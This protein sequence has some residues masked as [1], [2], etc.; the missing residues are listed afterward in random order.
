[1]NR[2]ILKQIKNL[3]NKTLLNKINYKNFKAINTN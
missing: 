3:T 1:M 2:K